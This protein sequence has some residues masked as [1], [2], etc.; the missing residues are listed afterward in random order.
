MLQ[1]SRPV[2]SLELGGSLNLRA[3][4]PHSYYLVGLT[5]FVQQRLEGDKVNKRSDS[6]IQDDLA[7][8]VRV[9][10]DKLDEVKDKIE[11]AGEGIHHVNDIMDNMDRYCCQT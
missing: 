5:I 11:G 9:T 4:T 10:N 1:T 2:C 8:M 3:A 7:V 6:K